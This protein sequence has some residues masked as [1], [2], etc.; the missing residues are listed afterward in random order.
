MELAA[1]LGA[2]R[3]LIHSDSDFA[4]RHATGSAR[5]TTV[6]LQATADRIR[7]LFDG[8]DAV[9]LAWTPRHRN[10]AADGLARQALGLAPKP[11]AWPGKP[12]NRPKS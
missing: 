8:F 7:A 11:P 5:T 1:S 4:V 6:T 9:E 10:A 12:Q 2:R 3:L